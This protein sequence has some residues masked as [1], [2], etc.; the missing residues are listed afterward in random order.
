MIQTVIR[1]ERMKE[2]K[3][4]KKN[5]IFSIESFQSLN[6]QTLQTDVGSFELKARN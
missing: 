1:H 6:L 2:S 3:K 4:R 5:L